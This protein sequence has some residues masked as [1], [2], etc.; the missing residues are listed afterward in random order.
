MNH[1]LAA[2]APFGRRVKGNEFL[3]R[4]VHG[5][6]WSAV[7]SIGARA[8]GLIG[9]VVTA[10]VLGLEA[11]GELGMLQSTIGMFGAVAGFGLGL[12]STKYVA[13]FRARDPERAG[14]VIGVS[15]LFSLISGIAITI[16]VLLLATPLASH[17]LHAPHLAGGLMVGSLLLLF[18]A[19]NGSQLGA[20][21]GFEAFQLTARIQIGLAFIQFPLIILGVYLG[22]VTGVIT[23][24]VLVQGISCV[25]AGRFV[26]ALAKKHGI[27]FT[28]RGCW[29][30]LPLLWTFSLPAVLSTVLVVPVYWYLQTILAQ[31]AGYA[32]IAL[33]TVAAQWRTYLQMLPQF[34]SS[35]YLPVASSIG[36]EDQG[37][38]RRLMFLGI[39][40]SAGATAIVALVLILAAPLILRIYGE[41]FADGVTIF[42]LLAVT[43]VADSVNAILLQTLLAA[44]KGWWRL[45]SNS[46]WCV[47]VM[48]LGVMLVPAHG[49]LG[50]AWA[51]CLG[52]FIHLMLQ[53]F[54][55]YRLMNSVH[56]TPVHQSA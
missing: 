18:G 4:L 36:R 48:I 8:L 21:S 25:V 52:Q 40:A 13:E 35:S 27:P 15:T 30:E 43:A 2:L 24:L 17:T 56:S 31:S 38:R 22:G 55:V 41:S 33:Y 53:G 54:L 44:E 11:Y 50:L 19:W 39:G 9:F 16:L 47:I 49:A 45:I 20:L 6:F 26:R 14:R 23:A 7:G 32:E 3:M 46:V 12:T 42:R 37:K 10:R 1:L 5:T 51:L 28:M 34:M 29:S